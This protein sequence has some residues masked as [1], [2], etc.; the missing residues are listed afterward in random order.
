MI[1]INRG[2]KKKIVFLLA[3]L[4]DYYDYF[5]IRGFYRRFY[6]GDYPKESFYQ[7][8]SRLVK[9]GE[10]TKEKKDKK[11]YLRLTS[12]GEKIF[13]QFLSLKKLSQK[14]WDGYW[15]LVIFDIEEKE[16]KLRDELRKKLKEIGFFMWQKSIYI[17]PHPLFKNMNEYLKTRNL[18]PKVVCLET[19]AIGINNYQEFARKIFRLD[20]LKDQYQKIDYELS[21]RE[22]D[23]REQRLIKKNKE[24]VVKKIRELYL[25]F[26]ELVLKDPFLPEELLIDQWPR[27]SLRKRFLNLIG[28]E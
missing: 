7:M 2:L 19:K 28:K 1:K 16:R 12:K 25:K 3:Y 10:I 5:S 20:L 11:I 22:K 4:L 14:K 6:L 21:L 18:F 23:L 26:Q 9:S 27:E 17:S 15:R 13:K 8:V 24:K